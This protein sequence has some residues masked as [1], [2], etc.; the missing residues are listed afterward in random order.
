[1]TK[2][3]EVE[4]IIEKPVEILKYVEKTVEVPVVQTQVV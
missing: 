1:V 2:I 3:V 4:K